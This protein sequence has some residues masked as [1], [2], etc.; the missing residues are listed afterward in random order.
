MSIYWMSWIGIASAA[1]FGCLGAFI[2]SALIRVASAA[3]AARGDGN[4]STARIDSHARARAT[5]GAAGRANPEPMEP[6]TFVERK[7]DPATILVPPPMV[8][9]YTLRDYLI[10][11]SGDDQVWAKV[12]TDF[13]GTAAADKDVFAV[14]Q[15]S[16]RAHGMD[17]GD[18]V[19]HVSKH[20]LAMLIVLTH[21]GL[22]VRLADSLMASHAQSG[23]T[24]DVYDKTV[25]ALVQVL[26]RY[27][28]PQESFPRLVE[29]VGELEPR[30]VTVG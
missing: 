22:N 14:F 9:Q 2:V 20:F 25:T 4:T 17:V 11:Y 15:A 26:T 23:I 3:W 27:G 30:I 24:K 18:L 12:V 16:A 13:Y 29:M 8:G 28:T 7:P 6:A 21:V 1:F 5:T 19:A 10:H